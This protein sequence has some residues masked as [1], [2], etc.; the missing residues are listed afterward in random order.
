MSSCKFARERFWEGGEDG[1]CGV[2]EG[3]LLRGARR[4]GCGEC[5][6]GGEFDLEG[7]VARGRR[8]RWSE[9]VV[10][11]VLVGWGGMSGVEM[12]RERRRDEDVGGVGA[13]AGCMLREGGREG[14]DGDRDCD[15]GGRCGR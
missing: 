7:R 6:L 11:F 2:W 8:G 15:G 5:E 9:V 1:C 10:V 13:N 12:K 4:R 3:S 14:G